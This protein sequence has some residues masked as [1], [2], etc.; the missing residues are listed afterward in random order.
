MVS[1]PE[2]NFINFVQRLLNVMV[3]YIGLCTLNSDKFNFRP[4]E[5]AHNLNKITCDCK[6]VP[7]HYMQASRGMEV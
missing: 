3:V 6:D 4:Y 1:P 2:I 5:M 7:V